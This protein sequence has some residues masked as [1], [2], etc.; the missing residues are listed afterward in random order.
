[1]KKNLLC[2]NDMDLIRV[3]ASK[4]VKQFPCYT[5]NPGDLYSTGYLTLLKAR[6]K[7]ENGKGAKFKTYAYNAIYRAMIDEMVH[8]N[9]VV[10][11]PQDKWPNE[12]ITRINENNFYLFDSQDEYESE[13]SKQEQLNALDEVLNGLKQEERE[14]VT[15]KFGFTG[16]KHTCRELGES[17]GVSTQ[18][19]HKRIN[20][21]ERQMQERIMRKCA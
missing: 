7:Y 4:L 20:T 14:L 10:S 3:I 19:I 2:Q 21:I 18:A 9:S 13:L 8:L 6:E 12:I 5:C 11:L 16:K 1:M 15:S 17:H